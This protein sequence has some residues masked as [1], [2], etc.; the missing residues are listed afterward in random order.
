VQDKCREDNEEGTDAGAYPFQRPKNSKSSWGELDFREERGQANF[1][2]A[3]FI[4]WD[5]III[6]LPFL[7]KSE[8]K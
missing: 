3:A 4:S 1:E 6:R 7:G 2:S 8:T 5:Q